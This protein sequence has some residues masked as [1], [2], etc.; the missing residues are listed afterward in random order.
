MCL[1]RLTLAQDKSNPYTKWIK[2]FYLYKCS[3][4]KK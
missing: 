1:I 4:Q 2:L 3:P